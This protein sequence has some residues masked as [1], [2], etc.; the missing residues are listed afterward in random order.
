MLKRIIFKNLE[1][2]WKIIEINKHLA[3]DLARCPHDHM[4]EKE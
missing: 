1:A 4:F 2:T 3:D